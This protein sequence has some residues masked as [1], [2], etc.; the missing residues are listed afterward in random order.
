MGKGQKKK[1][2][3]GAPLDSFTHDT[4]SSSSS[5]LL[6]RKRSISADRQSNIAP[7]Q[8][9]PTSPATPVDDLPSLTVG[10]QETEPMDAFEMGPSEPSATDISNSLPSLSANDIAQSNQEIAA[11][12]DLFATMKRALTSM[13]S[14]SDRL[15]SQN[16]KL[17]TCALDIK[18]AEQVCYTV[19]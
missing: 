7:F 17:I 1:R 18:A 11:M 2:G 15:G 5:A 13:R 19:F 8:T 3:A 10:L 9:P 4:G 16:E 6:K 14:A 12:A